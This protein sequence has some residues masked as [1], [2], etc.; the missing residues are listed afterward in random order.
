MPDLS[1]SVAPLGSR[2]GFT[3]LE[4]VIAILILSTALVGWV[5]TFGSELRTLSQA[6]T[7]VV[8]VELAEDRLAAIELYARNRLPSIPDSLRRGTFAAPFAEYG[9]TAESN[10]MSG[11][12]LV[13]VTVVVTGPGA[14]HEL[15]TVL[16]LPSLRRVEP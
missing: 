3:L 5:A 8:A 14:S 7:V 6:R 4:V 11:Q 12:E 9:W 10:S 13:E 15:R 16:P 1:A 2:S